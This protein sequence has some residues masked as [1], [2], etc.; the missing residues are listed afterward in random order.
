MATVLITISFICAVPLAAFIPVKRVHTDIP[1]LALVLW[2]TMSNVLHGINNSLFANT[3][4]VKSFV[5]CDISTKFLL[6]VN[7]AVPG[8]LLCIGRRLELVSST[9]KIVESKVVKRNMMMFEILCCFVFPVIYMTLHLLAQ[10]H[11]FDIIEDFGCFAAVHPS[12]PGL[13]LVWVLPLAIGAASLLLSGLAVQ[14]SLRVT[15]SAFLTHLEPRTTMSSSHFTRRVITSTVMT[16]V[17]VI[18]SLFGVFTVPALVPWKSWEW[19]HAR[20]GEAVVLAKEEIGS[21]RMRWWSILAMS[22]AY[23]LLSY[24]LGEEAR[25]MYKWIGT[26]FAKRDRFFGWIKGLFAQRPRLPRH[27]SRGAAPNS[28]QSLPHMVELK[29]GWDDMVDFKPST[30]STWSKASKSSRSNAASSPPSTPTSSRS[31]SA[32][33]LRNERPTTSVPMTNEDRAF[34]DST[35]SYLGSPTAQTLGITSPPR[36][37]P[38]EKLTSPPSLTAPSPV[39]SLPTRKGL[40]PLSLVIADPVLPQD[41]PEFVSPVAVRSPSPRNPAA[42]GISAV[43]QADW[44]VPPETPSP[45]PSRYSR[46]SSRSPDRLSPTLSVESPM[47]SPNSATALYGPGRPFEAAYDGYGLPHRPASPPMRGPSLKQSLQSLRESWDRGRGKHSSTQSKDGIFM[48]VVQE[49]V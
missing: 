23:I 33:S 39:A 10:H 31:P 47:V 1:T 36:P 48:T 27:V 25:D 38:L 46:H 44:P 14:H 2:L 22:V 40:R 16:C 5:W 7:V 21:T 29:S 28:K 12:T 19:A 9:R 3:V 11:R 37:F 41:T 35:L 24:G 18:T 8:A 45:V 34:M 4:A 15:G 32:A 6:G 30:K 26:T 49:T 20:M 17:S 13:I 42:V 43:I